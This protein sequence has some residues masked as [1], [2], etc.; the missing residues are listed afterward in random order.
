MSFRL[1]RILA[2][3]ASSAISMANAEVVIN[4]IMYHPQSESFFEEYVELHNTGNTEVNVGRWRL[5]SGVTFT[6]PTN[7]VI[8]PKGY[9]VVVANPVVF[10]AKYP[11]ITNFVGPWRAGDK[12]SNSANRITLAD[13][14]QVVR[15]EVRY[16]DDGDWATRRRDDP[17]SFGHRGWHWRSEADGFGKSLELINAAFDN[18]IGQNWGDSFAAEGT[19]GAAN[20]I[21]ATNL[22]PLIREVRYFPLLPKSSDSVTVSARVTDDAGG[23]VAVSVAYRD[24]GMTEF[25]TVP[26]FDD[27]GHDDGVPNDGIYAAQLPARPDKTVVE[28]Y[29]TATDAASLSRTWPKPAVDFDN[30]VVQKTNCLYQVDNTVYAGAMPIYRLILTTADRAELAAINDDDDDDSHARFNATFITI[31]GTGSELRYLCGLRNRGHFSAHEDPQSFNLQIPHDTEWKGRVGLNFNGRYSYLQLLGSAIM[32]KA[33]IAAPDSHQI[34]LRVNG[35]DLTIGHT[36]VSN[37]FYVCNEVVDSRFIGSHYPQTGDGNIYRARRTDP[38]DPGFYSEADLEF[39]PPMPGQSPADPYRLLYFKE[40]NEEEDNWS[41]LITLTQTLNDAQT[42]TL[43][44]TPTWGPTFV[45][46]AFRTDVDQW[47]RWFAVQALLGN[48]ESSLSRGI[49][50]DYYLFFAGND[51]KARLISHDLDTILGAGDAVSSQSASIY[52]MIRHEA[53]EWPATLAPTPLYAFIRNPNF[54]PVYLRELHQLLTGPLSQE[55]FN[56]LADQLLTGVV[57]PSVIQARKDWYSGRHASILSQIP[58]ELSVINPPLVVNTPQITLMGFAN[59]TT[60]RAVTANTVLANYNT[61]RVNA[62]SGNN[63]STVTGLWT[64]TGIPLLPGFN[65]ITFTTFDQFGRELER[66]HRDV[67]YDDTSV[68]IIS[69]VQNNNVINGNVTWAASDGPFRVESNV[70]VKNGATLTILLGTNVFFSPGTSLTVEPGGRLLA[71]GT[72]SFPIR[73]TSVAGTPGGW[74]GIIINGSATSLVESR[75]HHAIIDGNNGTAIICN[76][77][78]NVWFDHVDFR[79][80]TQRYLDLSEASFVV[81]NCIFPMAAPS[82]LYSAVEALLNPS[83][84]SN[85]I[86]R[87]CF[88]GKMHSTAGNSNDVINVGGGNRPGGIFQFINNVC[89]G[90]DDDILN[91]D[92]T[93][94]WIEGN[95]FMN[96][97]RNGSSTLAGA[98]SADRAGADTCQLTMVGNLIINVDHAVVASEG[99]FATVLNNT[100]IQQ[101]VEGGTESEGAVLNL[102][103]NALL[104]ADPGLGFHIEGNVIRDVEQLV[105][106]YDPT[107]SSVIFQNNLL[108]SPWN[109]PGT[110]NTVSDPVLVDPKKIPT[111]TRDNYRAI[112]STIRAKLALRPASPG[113]RTGPNGTDKGGVRQFGVSLNGIPGGVTNQT[114]AAITVGT[115][116]A[117]E[118]VV[119]AGFPDGSGWPFYKWRLNDGP[120]SALTSTSSPII[121][122]DLTNGDHKLEVIGRNDASTDQNSDFYGSTGTMATVTWTVNTNHVP[123]PEFPSIRINE[124]LASNTETLHFGGVHPDL[125]ELQNTGNVPIDLSGWGLTDN[126]ANLY[127]Y[128]FPASTIINPGEYLVVYATDSNAVPQPRTGF[129]LKQRG[130]DLTLSRSLEQGGGIVDSI[131]WGAQL[132]DLSIGRYGGSNWT[133]SR[134]TFGTSNEAVPTGN[135][136]FVRI[137][138]WLAD[139]RALF[140]DD[141]IELHN[142]CSLP[143]DVGLLCLTNN[144]AGL[145][146]GDVIE[147]RTF[148][149]PNGY[150]AFIANGVL[151]EPDH[152]GFKLD[153][154]QGAIG[155]S[156]FE[157]TP[158]DIVIYGPQT[159][160]VSQG[161]SPNGAERFATFHTPTPGAANQEIPD[162]RQDAILLRPRQPWRYF[163]TPTAEPPE[164]PSGFSFT[165]PNYND[166]AWPEDAGVLYVKTD[167]IPANTDGFVKGT[168]LP[169]HAPN[170]PYQTYYFRTRFTYNGPTAGTVLRATLLCDDGCVIYLNGQEITPTT[171]RIRINDS[172]RPRYNTLATAPSPDLLETYELP[173]DAL[174][175]GENVIA[176]SVHQVSDQSGIKPSNDVTWGLKLDASI[177][178]PAGGGLVINEVLSINAGFQNPDGSLDGWI[179]LANAGLRD[180]DLTGFSLTDDLETPQKYVIPAGTALTP[181]QRRVIQC[182]G[183]AAPST[184]NT[185]FGLTGSGGALYLFNPQ[186]AGGALVDSVVYGQQ[187]PDYSLSRIPDRIGPF[188]L[189]VPTRGAMN[190]QAALASPTVV[191]INEWVNNPVPG[192]PSWFELYNSETKPV[193]LSGNFLSDQLVDKTKHQ[194]PP[195][196]FI[197]GSGSARWL[198]FIADNDANAGANHVN[199]SIATGEGI[200]F[201]SA[202]GV[203]LD[204]V[205][206]GPQLRGESMGLFPDG[207]P[208]YSILSPTPG[209]QNSDT[210]VDTDEDGIPDAWELANGLDPNSPVDGPLDRDRDGE[211]NLHEYFFG[212]DPRRPGSLVP[213]VTPTGIAGR[214][215]ISFKAAAGRTYT[216]RFKNS[217]LSPAWVRLHD[218]PASPIDRIVTFFDQAPAPQQRFYIIEAPGLP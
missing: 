43:L 50:D 193:L 36:D 40:N 74:N 187:V 12:L 25:T 17:P 200:G 94:A 73:F 129:S 19:P 4:E 141:F 179:E 85:A 37:G 109:G 189:G 117:N 148:I 195:L 80:N 194:I 9:L 90:S 107:V 106:N 105:R 42:S 57:E 97:H 162:G 46:M 152:L 122:E 27:G 8:P 48:Q 112:A 126:L 13:N 2:L 167:A 174:V 209:A 81:S 130:D 131:S 54:A 76:A 201:F 172:E 127:K 104:L 83:P 67:F 28:F 89:T 196:T 35:N 20:S 65:R 150:L 168:E 59:T 198:P 199:F 6:V 34:Q 128:T 213:S 87:D 41:D 51:G 177:P 145:P 137:N 86:I 123:L 99:S 75:I 217:L 77:N 3:A 1:T 96:V 38:G 5:T 185:G 111:P 78:A 163:A 53:S 182:K 210:L 192:Q 121:L 190:V 176:V 151:T 203:T 159:S 211:S 91:L 56:A 197:G 116:I 215:A 23:A 100:I 84:S 132:S 108:T 58:Q 30:T 92:G 98:I 22:A 158:I 156:T 124:V 49:G 160:D 33:G 68:T 72:S 52:R 64:A 205:P 120:W 180:V 70:V 135:P 113:V 161:R 62:T 55:N 208:I 164:D 32:R 157:P 142:P 71:E 191:R 147:P 18:S 66:I 178:E 82:A 39:L 69:T 26:M 79:N 15:D 143:V 134:P 214:Y 173:G 207:A 60:T 47:M 31:D 61:W 7:T 16:A 11:A 166:S 153:P 118:T 110:S 88:F 119:N 125:I 44:G 140:K 93:D 14:N 155:L 204:S 183:N 188:T 21:V 175:N 114:G 186:A 101:T 95:I 102:S 154:I 171:G 10:S 133:L 206:L 165:D 115:V 63:F 29:V 103:D 181:G 138:E 184:T 146:R 170:H 45:S 212:T 202:N 139:A 136:A 169:A 216:I 24:D 144:P 149:A 218:V